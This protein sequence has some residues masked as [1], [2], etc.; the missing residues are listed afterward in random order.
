[1]AVEP[2]P[3]DRVFVAG[4]GVA[5]GPVGD[6]WSAFN[7]DRLWFS[8]RS[9]QLSRGDHIFALGAGRS[10]AV[11]G[12]FEVTSGGVERD[13]SPYD[14]SRWPYAVR[15][16]PLAGVDPASARQVPGVRA[17]RATAAQ[18]RDRQQRKT[19]YAALDDAEEPPSDASA[20]S[21]ASAAAPRPVELEAGEAYSWDDLGSMFGFRPDYFSIT[22]GMPVSTLRDAVLLITHPEGGR[23]FDYEDYWDGEDLIYKGRGRSGDQERSGANLDVAENRRTLYAFEAAGSKTLRYLGRP[24]CSE[25]RLG[26][27]PG[28]DGVMRRVLQFRLRFPPGEG[29]RFAT[30]GR[31]GPRATASGR[32]AADGTSTDR[33]P[34][35][36]DP[37]TGP[38]DPS[39]T[40]SAA[41]YADEAI[42]A[43][44][45]K[46]NAGH[47]AIL[48]VLDRALRAGGWTHIEEIPSA[49]DLRG[50]DPE[51][52]RVIFEAKTITAT[53][54]LSQCRGGY[55]QLTEYRAEYG[56][57]EDELCL[58]VNHEVSLRRARLLDRLGVAVMLVRDDRCVAM[59]DKG[60]A[61]ADRVVASAQALNH[62]ST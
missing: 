11:L 46:A 5:D 49:I 60:S 58:I 51:G 59:N 57:P 22:G 45:E 21:E 40:D 26:R 30:G 50:T 4:V 28:K 17:P 10:S 33:T 19:L 42:Q 20:A 52:R 23:S 44:R 25:E 53:N 41:G 39:R 31:S 8:N 38:P 43:K 6:D 36:F 34:R 61:I 12:L 13:P 14:P 54:E 2:H 1:M 15:V 62:A 37:E 47:H 3:F 18:V 27:A 35:P 7:Q 56:A 32:S 9:N 48:V 29:G 24:T 55:A 16:R